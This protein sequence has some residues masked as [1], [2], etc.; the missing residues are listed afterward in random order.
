MTVFKRD[1]ITMASTL[2][3]IMKMFA[4]VFGSLQF[5]P[6]APGRMRDPARKITPSA[7]SRIERTMFSLI[8]EKLAFSPQLLF[9]GFV[10][11]M[12][13]ETFIF[14]SLWIGYPT[15]IPN[16]TSCFDE[17]Q[18]IARPL[19]KVPHPKTAKKLMEETCYLQ[20]QPF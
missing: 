18:K 11:V 17:N 13:E 6:K 5:V 16:S 8:P 20:Q 14:G 10:I 2:Q 15:T 7:P 3:K 9:F 12:D 1:S 19:E 4:A